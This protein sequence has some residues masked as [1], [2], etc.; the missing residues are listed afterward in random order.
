[1]P[2]TASKEDAK[3][4]LE[5][6]ER[7]AVES[8]VRPEG[9]ADAVWE[10]VQEAR[11]QGKRVR[12]VKKK[13]GKGGKVGEQEKPDMSPVEIASHLSTWSAIYHMLWSGEIQHFRQGV[14]TDGQA[15][16]LCVLCLLIPVL[17]VLSMG[18]AFVCV[19]RIFAEGF[20]VHTGSIVFVQFL[21]T[22]LLQMSSTDD[23]KAF[24]HLLNLEESAVAIFLYFIDLFIGCT[25]T[26]SWLCIGKNWNAY[27]GPKMAIFLVIFATLHNPFYGVRHAFS[28][29]L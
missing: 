28:L 16:I 4:K 19:R 11:R 8:E 26:Y 25:F 1:M 24:M 12:L 23:G 3:A 29:P 21:R 10:K 27:H 13:K 6:L 15:I 17:P 2:S 9:V 20:E 5:Q 14:L 7:D 22:T 18:I